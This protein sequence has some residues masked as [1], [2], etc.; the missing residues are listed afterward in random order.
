MR[1]IDSSKLKIGMISADNVYTKAGQL[2][3]PKNT[4]L[5]RQMISQ[6]LNYRVKSVPII[7]NESV[8]EEAKNAIQKKESVQ[9]THFARLLET[10]Q[11]AEFKVKYAKGVEVVE[12][13]FNDII[14][15]NR[16]IPEEELI[17]DTVELFRQNGTTYSLFGMMHAMKQI[18]DSTFAHCI[19]VSLISRL[20]G[21]WANLPLED[22]D[23][24][25]LA[26]LLHDIG[27][28][29]I[30]QDILLKPGKL[31][32][33]EFEFIKMHPT[34]GYNLLKDKNLDERIKNAVLSHHERYD[35]TGYPS[36]QSG[37]KLNDFE[38]IIAIADVYDALTSNRCYRLAMCPFDGIATFE[39]EGLHKYHP[40][41][42]YTFLEKI[43]NS[44]LNSEVLLSNGENARI[45]YINQKLTRPIVQLEKDNSILNLEQNLDVYIE[46]II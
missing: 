28:C 31:T 9:K 16:E 34:F 37:H 20:I 17:T 35:G 3:I 29:Q 4:C 18:D 21:T 38:S 46:A 33:Q 7:D 41:F 6:L 13:S 1:L 26:G 43:A 45:I 32:N 22:L 39:Q 42:I 27:K 10:P 25:T 40:K 8:P 11:F 2:L 15:K 44:Y 12:K 5:T 36:K 24:L 23:A 19:N 14:F 30:P